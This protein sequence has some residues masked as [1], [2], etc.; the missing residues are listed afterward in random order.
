MEVSG[1]CRSFS[2]AQASPSSLSPACFPPRPHLLFSARSQIRSSRRG[3][4]T[5][6]P[7]ASADLQDVIV[8]G[9]VLTAVSAA[10]YNGLKGEPQVCDLCQGV[11]GAKCFACEGIGTRASQEKKNMAGQ[12]RDLIGR[13]ANPSACNVCGG[14]GMNLCSKCRGSGYV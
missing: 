3:G 11:G 9:A 5:I 2:C 8:G 7:R 6:C 12:R 1:T 10:L 4:N 13:V 14:S